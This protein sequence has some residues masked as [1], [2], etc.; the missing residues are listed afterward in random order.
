MPLWERSHYN[1][2]II[3]V[4]W[5]TSERTIFPLFFHYTIEA[6][7]SIWFG[8]HV[9]SLYNGCHT[10]D[11]IW[12]PC[13]VIIQ[14]IWFGYHVSS[15]HN[16]CYRL[17]LIWFPYS[18]LYIE[19]QMPQTRCDMIS[20]FRHYTSDTLNSMWYDFYLFS[21]YIVCSKHDVIWFS[22]LFIIHQ[23][24]QTRCDLISIFLSLYNGWPDYVLWF[25][26]LLYIGCPKQCYIQETHVSWFDAFHTTIDRVTWWITHR[27]IKERNWIGCLNCRW[28]RPLF[29]SM[30][31]I[32]SQIST[33]I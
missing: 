31:A 11:V 21:L 4:C 12:F 18:L 9:S 22:C 23:I 20:M 6:T 19:H 24:P 7:G 28:M 30:P 16:E 33:Q 5:V 32:W 1:R 10:L 8:Y 15:L 27:S 29:H 25:L 13:F 14:W 17:N 3:A 26:C 2:N